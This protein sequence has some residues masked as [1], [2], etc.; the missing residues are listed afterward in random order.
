MN[1][2]TIP[3]SAVLM[4]W[5]TIDVLRLPERY[6]LFA[7]KPFSCPLCLSFWL[8][9]C[10]YASPVFIQNMAFVALSAAALAAYLDR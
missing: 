8:A 7:R 10:L 1:I 4:A 3:I 9:V 6:R 5:V 2:L